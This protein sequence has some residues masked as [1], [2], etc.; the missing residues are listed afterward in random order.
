M[1]CLGKDDKI[2]WLN[3]G[4]ISVESPVEEPALVELG[5]GGSE[6]ENPFQSLSGCGESW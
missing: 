3:V 4:P 2:D 6:G 5:S 1:R